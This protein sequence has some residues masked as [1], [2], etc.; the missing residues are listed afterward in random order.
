MPLVL[1]NML[2]SRPPLEL[3]DEAAATGLDAAK[4]WKCL[5]KVA[6]SSGWGR[7]DK[8]GPSLCIFL[9]GKGFPLGWRKRST[10]G[11]MRQIRTAAFGDRRPGE[12]WS[13]SAT[14]TVGLLHRFSP[15]HE[16]TFSQ[17]QGPLRT[18]GRG[19]GAAKAAQPRRIP[20]REINLCFKEPCY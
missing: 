14:E 8:W 10:Q 18:K 5:W 12:G 13:D 20:M 11:K 19:F 1:I 15:E 3:E 2:V 17:R 16:A 7:G 9:G 4:G 6:G